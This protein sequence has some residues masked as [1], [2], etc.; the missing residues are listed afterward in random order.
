[1]RVLVVNAGSSS[2]KLSVVAGGDRQDATQVERWEG[3]GLEEVQDFV[4]TAGE[5]RRSATVSST[6]APAAPRA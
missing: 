5:W 3:T 1:M 4:E 2:L 6:E